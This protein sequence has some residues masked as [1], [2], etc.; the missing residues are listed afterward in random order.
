MHYI[1]ANSTPFKKKPYYI[2]K[3]GLNLK[4][5][6][7]VTI[8]FSLETWRENGMCRFILKVLTLSPNFEGF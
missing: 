6:K 3:N 4:N 5:Y 2:G 1:D 8:V 7:H